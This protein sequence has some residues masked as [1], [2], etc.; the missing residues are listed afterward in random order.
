MKQTTK[1]TS[2]TA[3]QPH[4]HGAPSRGKSRQED[5]VLK[6]TRFGFVPPEGKSSMPGMDDVAPISFQTYVP[7]TFT[8]LG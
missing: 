2:T 4:T 3:A 8:A 6:Y 5:L 7:C 1:R